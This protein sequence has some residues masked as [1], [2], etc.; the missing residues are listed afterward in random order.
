MRPLALVI[1]GALGREVRAIVDGRG[2]DADVFGVPALHHLVP[3]RIVEAVD[4]R[5]AELAPKYERV[6]VVYGDCGTGEAMDAVL[7]RHGAVRLRGPHCYEMFAGAAEFERLG[8]E[9]PGTF[10]LTDWLV[11]SFQRAV[12]RPLGLDRHPELREVYF[13][14][15]TDVLY[16]CQ[17][18]DERR[19]AEAA[20]IAGYL[21]LPMEVRHVGL[22]EL[23]SR[24]AEMVGEPR[25]PHRP[26]PAAR[27]L[28]S[29]ENNS[30][31]P[32]DPG[33]R[34]APGFLSALEAPE[35]AGE[36]ESRLAEVAERV[37]A[38]G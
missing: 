17:F 7:A 18:P 28:G 4:R 27:R 22:G 25:F 13:G 33:L 3:R 5:L 6:V 8:E 2:W 23:E 21:G 36:L 37:E 1:C 35:G 38:G 30:H 29:P 20:E 12:V 9:R 16:L 10:F 31:G 34:A 14:S 19:V 32:G 26:P 24:L 11:R 15:Y